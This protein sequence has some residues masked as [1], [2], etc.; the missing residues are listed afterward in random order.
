MKG[1]QSQ[2]R[3]DEEREEKGNGKQR[4]EKEQGRGKA[5]SHTVSETGEKGE[6]Q[7]SCPH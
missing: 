7:R 6:G 4:V 1:K 3:K 5:G 2:G